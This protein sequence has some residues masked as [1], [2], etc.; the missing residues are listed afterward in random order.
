M[1]SHAALLIGEG[2]VGLSQPKAILSCAFREP[3]VNGIIRIAIITN[4]E[5]IFD[6]L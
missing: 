3:S 1:A 2:W 4:Q 5:C 6:L